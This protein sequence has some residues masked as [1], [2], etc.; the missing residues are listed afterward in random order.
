MQWIKDIVAGLVEH[1]G[2]SDIY[3]ICDFLNIEIIKKTNINSKSYY[4][5]DSFGSEI[6][7]LKPGLNPKKE[8]AIIAHELGHAILHTDLSTAF[9]AGNRL[10]NKCKIEK[11]AD[12]FAATLLTWEIDLDNYSW[13]GQT[14]DQL[15]EEIDVTTD[16]LKIKSNNQRGE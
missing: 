16:L 7:Y 3:T 5:R 10:A 6:I 9:F 8:K 11:Q 14:I 4:V 1:S 2:T 13:D 15:A 12:Y